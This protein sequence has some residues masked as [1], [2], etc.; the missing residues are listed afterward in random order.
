MNTPVRLSR[1]QLAARLGLQPNTLAH[2]A[3]KGNGP[4]FILI[5]RRA[6]YDLAEVERWERERTHQS[7]AEYDAGPGTL[8]L[9]RAKAAEGRTC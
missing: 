9:R 2:W 6:R 5:N 3:R 1:T 7:T 4:K 8:G